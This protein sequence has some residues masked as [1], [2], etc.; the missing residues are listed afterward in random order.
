MANIPPQENW[1]TIAEKGA[2]AGSMNAILLSYTCPN[3]RCAEIKSW[4]FDEAT[5]SSSVQA[6]FAGKGHTVGYQYSIPCSPPMNA[7]MAA[8]DGN[9]RLL[10]V[11]LGPGDTFFIVVT[12]AMGAGTWDVAFS[13]RE[14]GPANGNMGSWAE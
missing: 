10:N 12:A 3:N 2:D 6:R 9:H 11:L 13:V 4:A 14:I 8:T 7:D 1:F 5:G